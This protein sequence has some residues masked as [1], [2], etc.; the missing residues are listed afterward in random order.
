[1]MPLTVA[2]LMVCVLIDSLIIVT[3]YIVN[4]LGAKLPDWLFWLSLVILDVSSV[5]TVIGLQAGWFSGWEW[6]VWDVYRV[7]VIVFIITAVFWGYDIY[8]RKSKITDEDQ[9]DNNNP[10][11][12]DVEIDSA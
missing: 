4:N 7:F 10:E 12:D 11:H 9:G 2:M 3:Y 5:Y 6:Y 8:S 1:M